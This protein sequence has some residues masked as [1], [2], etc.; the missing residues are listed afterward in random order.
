MWVVPL[1]YQLER[2]NRIMSGH[3]C[4]CALSAKKR[5]DMCVTIC[6]IAVESGRYSI[7]KIQVITKKE[8]KDFKYST[9][10]GFVQ[11]QKINLPPLNELK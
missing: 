11:P 7:N 9:E 8:D 3:S 10:Q 2:V 6:L 5:F 1:K 4:F